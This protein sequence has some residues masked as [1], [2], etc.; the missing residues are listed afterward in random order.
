MPRIAFA[1]TPLLTAL[2]IA[3][4]SDSNGTSANH[5]DGTSSGD[6]NGVCSISKNATSITMKMNVNGAVTTT[7]YDF[8]GGRLASQSTITDVS[9]MGSNA[10]YACESMANGEGFEASFDAGKCTVKQTAGLASETMDQVYQAQSAACDAAN[11]MANGVTNPTGNG[12]T[13]PSG[14]TSVDEICAVTKTAKSVSYTGHDSKGKKATVLF[15]FNADGSVTQVST[16]E[17][18]NSA[19][20]KA[21]CNTFNAY[22]DNAVASFNNGVCTITDYPFMAVSVD[23]LYE[24]LKKQCDELKSDSRF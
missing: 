2:L 14:A 20:A 5:Y 21:E 11:N 10:K 17:I 19:S 8:D 6:K 3:C 9:A 1:A 15:T 24:E 22:A 13:D 4:G 12:S 7:V 16:F 18:E 23:Y